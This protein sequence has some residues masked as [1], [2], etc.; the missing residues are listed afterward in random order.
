MAKAQRAL[1][2]N[3]SIEIM[4]LT[5]CHLRPLKMD[6]LPLILRWRNH[7]NVRKWMYTDHEISIDEH[8][9]W[10]ARVSKD[11]EC[12]LLIFECDR[13]AQGFVSLERITKWGLGKW[14]FYAAP[15]APKGTGRALGVAAIRYAFEIL[16][17][18]KLCGEVIGLNKRSLRLHEVLGFEHEGIL[19]DHYFDGDAYHDIH[20]F[21]LLARHWHKLRN[22]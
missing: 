16:K 1:Y 17:F 13:Q 20:L 14:G 11:D 3:L 22:I 15:S 9:Q 19:R 5:D 6:D 18:H 21:G 2:P 4:Q 8:L 12:I 7:P 10:Y